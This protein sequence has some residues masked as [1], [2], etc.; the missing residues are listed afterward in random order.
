MSFS[1][2]PLCSSRQLI[3]ALGR[4]GAY[5]GKTGKGSHASYNRKTRDGRILTAVV[6]LGKKE[7]PKSTLRRILSGLEIS[8]SDFLAEL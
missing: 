8:A 2:L 4:L 5:P 1:E 7:V 6:V 3:A